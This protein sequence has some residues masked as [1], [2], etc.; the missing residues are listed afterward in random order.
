MPKHRIEG[1]KPKKLVK[2]PPKVTDFQDRVYQLTK[3]IPKGNTLY[4]IKPSPGYV[5]TY[6][7]IAQAL[8]CKSSQAIG[9]ALK[10][11]PF[12]PEVPCHRVIS[13]TL[14]IGGFFGQ[15]NGEQIQR[16]LK[17]LKEE[18][19]LFKDGKLASTTQLYTF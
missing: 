12:A 1:L 5:T 15:V 4:N 14:E 17:L 16:K 6:K 7:E 19:V 11:N 8:N 13:S 2:K 3:T 10:K 9:Q 18:G